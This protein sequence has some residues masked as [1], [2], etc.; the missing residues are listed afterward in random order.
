MPASKNGDSKQ[1]L[2]IALVVFV[3]LTLILGVTT[4]FGYSDQANLQKNATEAKTNADNFQKQKN[5]YQAQALLLKAYAGLDLSDP[6]KQSLPQAYEQAGQS[7][8]SGDGKE[9]GTVNL[10][11][12]RATLDKNLGWN[13]G[14]QKPART[15]Q[16]TVVAL[17]TEVENTQKKLRKTEDDL[18]KAKD[19][20]DNLRAALED[21]VKDWKTK[22]ETAKNE[23]LKLRQD[24][25]KN[26]DDKLQQFAALSD[27]LGGIR[28]KQEEDE[29]KNARDIKK[30]KTEAADLR[31]KVKK[32]ER[33]MQPPDIE[34]FD[35]PKGQVTQV[36]PR[37]TVAW[38]N[39][40]S[41]DNVRAQQNLTFSIFNSGATRAKSD[42]KG[43]L[44]VA[45]V[46]GPHVSMARITDVT[47]PN[48]NPIV[49]GDVLVNP[50]W[51]PSNRE[52][53]AIA[54]IIDLTGQGRDNTDEFIRTL[55][56]QGIIVDAHLDLKDMTIKGEGLTAQTDYLITGDTPQF[57]DKDYVP[58]TDDK[59]GN[60][61]EDKRF[62]RKT[63]IHEKLT[64]MR[65][66]ARDLGVTIVPFKRFVALTGYK[67]P[68]TTGL[69]AGLD[70]ETGIRKNAAGQSETEKKRERPAPK[71][72]K[73]EDDEP[74]K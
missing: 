48:R 67:L 2:I 39:L 58:R 5:Y 18:K 32:M 19:S 61:P 16:D 33:E 50:A 24:N 64:E 62:E 35:T 60:A 73:N 22:F 56:Q 52:H 63:G 68:R 1:G 70:Y 9:A 8:P 28:K 13:P 30:A 46:M 4:W 42:R 21:E 15:Y 7:P 66:R 20:Y 69:E 47:D 31:G 72:E 11:N 43:A 6:E 10:A 74:A 57:S 23:N 53:V 38:I 59:E 55:R 41:A 51:S 26:L 65:N 25:E 71:K 37:G 27:Q 3:V 29:S 17:T 45:E 44:E 14:Q 34:K 54:G 40:G 36:D 12:V 49:P